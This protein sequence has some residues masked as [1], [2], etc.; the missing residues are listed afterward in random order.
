[1]I[2]SSEVAKISHPL[3]EKCP[4]AE[5]SGP[6]F[7]A[8]GLNREIYSVNLRNQSEYKKIRTRKNSAFGYFSHSDRVPYYGTNKVQGISK[9]FKG[10]KNSSLNMFLG[11]LSEKL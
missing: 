9:N 6:Y 8:F 7:P 5:F 4:N 11:L 10:R 2:K 1:M 3:R